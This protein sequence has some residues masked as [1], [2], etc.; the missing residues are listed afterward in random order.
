ML[1]SSLPQTLCQDQ[2]QILLKISILLALQ[3]LV[4]S[5][6]NVSKATIANCF[7]KVKISAENQ[8]DALEDS[9]NRFKALLD[10]LI[11]LRQCNPD[12]NPD[13]LSAVHVVDIDSSLTKTNTPTINK[14]EILE[15]V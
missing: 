11:E 12:L 4:A 10:N 13:E 3:S 7:R 6:K 15:L 14:K 9:D 8:V 5:W 2:G 1:K